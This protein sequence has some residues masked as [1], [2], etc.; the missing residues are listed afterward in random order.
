MPIQFTPG[1]VLERGDIDLF[2]IDGSG[3]PTN[4]YEISYAL[5]YVD[6]VGPPIGLEVLIGSA[7]R[8]PVNPQLGE[9]YAAL[10]IPPSVTLG[11]Y[12]IRWTFKETAG[13]VDT[14]VVQEFEVISKDTSVVTYSTSEQALINSLRIL[15]R[16]NCVHGDELVEV[17]VDGEKILISM[18]EL[19]ELLGTD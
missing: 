9:Y 1:T 4:A 3:V 6:P 8:T 18:E 13:A 10:M 16:D 19:Y 7:T 2:L 12:R 11:T 17:D 15:I 14:V 5:Y